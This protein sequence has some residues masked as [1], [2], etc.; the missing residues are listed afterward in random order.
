MFK[1][2]NKN[3]RLLSVGNMGFRARGGSGLL[4]TPGCIL[5]ERK[6]LGEDKEIAGQ[7][8]EYSDE[9]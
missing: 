3:D 7:T 8:A 1:N 9:P 4:I 6:G 2:L 5:K